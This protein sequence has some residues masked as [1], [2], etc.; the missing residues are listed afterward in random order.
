MNSDKEAMIH[1]NHILQLIKN[2]YEQ[3]LD[4]WD[5]HNFLHLFNINNPFNSYDDFCMSVE[6]VIKDTIPT[7]NIQEIEK[8]SILISRILESGCRLFEKSKFDQ[9]YDLID[10]LHALPEALLLKELWNSEKFFRTYFTPY[11]KKWDKNFLKSEQKMLSK[12]GKGS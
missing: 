2:Y 11:R 5:F 10:L 1:N 7:N 4:V 12:K 9:L 6:I 8:Y 3:S